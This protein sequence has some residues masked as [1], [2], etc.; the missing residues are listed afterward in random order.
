MK[1]R[2]SNVDSPEQHVAKERALSKG[3][4]QYLAG[5]GPFCDWRNE[6]DSFEDIMV[7]SELFRNIFIH[8]TRAKTLLQSGMHSG[9]HLISMSLLPLQF[10]CLQL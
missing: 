1:A 2:P 4:M 8:S 9:D 10:S 6:R 3:F 7:S 5:T